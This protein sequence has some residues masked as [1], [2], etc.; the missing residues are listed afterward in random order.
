MIDRYSRPE[1]RELWSDRARYEA[2]LRVELAACEAM[3]AQG[4]VPAGTAAT[5]RGKVS[6]DPRRILEIEAR[7]RHDVIAFLTDLEQQAGDDVRWLHLGLTSSDVLD[8]S[9][10]LQ[11]G[12]AGELILGATDTLLEVLERRARQH[13]DLPMIGRTHGIHAE[14]TSLGLVFAGFFAELRRDRDR[15]RRALRAVAVGKISGAVRVYG[16]LPPEVEARALAALGLRPEPCATQ[17]VA[18]DRHAE[19]FGA[20][21]L[22]AAGCERIA[23]QVRHWQRTEV[24]EA[25]EPFGGGQKG[26]SAMPHKRNP[27]LSEN[28]CGL[29]RLVRGY[30]DTAL[31]NVP[32]WHERDISHS[33]VERVIGPDA[34][35]LVH[36]MLVRLAGLLDGLVVDEARVAENLGRTGGLFFSESVMLAL[37]RKG[38]HRQR[39]YELVQRQALAAL[40]RGE[41]FSELLAADPELGGLLGHEELAACF[42]MS[43][44]LRH[45]ETIFTRVFDQPEHEEG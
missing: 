36:F 44:H 45:V 35:T 39:A 42:D 38:L 1:M 37:V 18:R 41:D 7:T 29:A 11:L 26:S 20:L 16:N 9:F 8:T 33:S 27:I 15:L 22:T 32:L 6:I 25:R 43:H 12:Q 31:E 21:A 34:T 4:L 2:W 3:E 30:A 13:R 40:D 24:G 28:I 19:L 23:L 14:P 5:I 10:A 17:V